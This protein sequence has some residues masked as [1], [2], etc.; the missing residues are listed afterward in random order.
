MSYLRTSLESQG[1]QDRA[2]QLR[3]RIVPLDPLPVRENELKVHNPEDDGG[4]RSI[5]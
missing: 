2:L 3:S 1:T 5:V 4:G